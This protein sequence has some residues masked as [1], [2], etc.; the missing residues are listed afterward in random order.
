MT[1]SSTL[2]RSDRGGVGHANPLAD[3]RAASMDD[4]ICR[5]AL[6]FA[7]THKFVNPRVTFSGPAPDDIV[8]LRGTPGSTDYGEVRILMDWP[9]SDIDATLAK[10]GNN[11][12]NEMRAFFDGGM[13][14]RVICSSTDIIHSEF[15]GVDLD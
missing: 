9:Q 2:F 15:V 13:E 5:R 1:G 6:E 7:S 12:P 10:P 11:D 3:H 4:A 14:L 8:A